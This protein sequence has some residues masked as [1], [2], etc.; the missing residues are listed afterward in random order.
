MIRNMEPAWKCVNFKSSVD[1]KAADSGTDRHE[2]GYDDL[3]TNKDLDVTDSATGHTPA[4]QKKDELDLLRWMTDVVD[5]DD[6]GVDL[7]PVAFEEAWRRLG[8]RNGDVAKDQLLELGIE[9]GVDYMVRRTV[10]RGEHQGKVTEKVALRPDILQDTTTSTPIGSEQLE[11]WECLLLSAQFYISRM[12]RCR[13]DNC[14]ICFNLY[15]T[16]IQN[17]TSFMVIL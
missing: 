12:K 5:T 6:D 9:E 14:L 8:C 2:C 3:K 11:P 10:L 16:L 17:S 15:T 1:S 13:Q 7:F 4:E